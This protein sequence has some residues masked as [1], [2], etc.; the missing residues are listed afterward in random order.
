M[1]KITSDTVVV[2]TGASSGIGRATAL[3]FARRGAKLVLAARR[4]EVLEE[5]AEE[6]NRYGGE[7]VAVPTD[8]TSEDAVDALARR[9]VERFGRIDVWV[10][11][12][13]VTLFGRIEQAPSAAYRRVIETNLF[14]CV[15]GARAAMQAFRAQGNGVLVNVASQLGKVGSP[16]VSAYVASKF[17]IV[18]LSESLREEALDTKGIRVSTVLPAS[19]DTPLFQHAANYTGRAVKPM[20]PIYDP[21]DVADAIVRCAERPAREVMVGAAGRVLT[22]LR[23]V[24]PAAA[25]RV[26]ARQVDRDHFQKRPAAA[27]DGNL[28][29]PVA[30][31]TGVSGGWRE[32][33][34][35]R[36]RLPRI[37]VLVGLG[38][39]AWSVL[40]PRGHR[41]A[42]LLEDAAGR[43]LSRLLGGAGDEVV[44]DS[45]E[46]LG[47]A[48]PSA[49]GR[50]FGSTRSAPLAP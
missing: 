40:R 50:L 6:C 33:P 45:A 18:G 9:A 27:T 16:Y 8:V 28:F 3:A 13:A 42:S 25:E 24:T 17:A 35:S 47:R 4:A 26:M 30:F 38:L 49:L 48:L 43:R 21:G 7:A 41:A 19:I 29:A 1:P 10:N 44:R 12:A 23:R 5:V 22:A 34:A 14:G 39:L 46:G 31:G 15:H 32:P 37:P 36:R 2:I 11:N 20:D